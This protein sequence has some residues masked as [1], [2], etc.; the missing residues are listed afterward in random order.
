M[1]VEREGSKHKVFWEHVQAFLY[2]RRGWG[3]GSGLLGLGVRVS[4]GLIV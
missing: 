1:E 4:S 2:F 3:G